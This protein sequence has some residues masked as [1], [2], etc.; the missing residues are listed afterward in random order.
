VAS[1]DVG[2]ALPRRF[3][4]RAAESLAL[5]L[6]QVDDCWHAGRLLLVTP[7]K[8]EPH[9]VPLE[10]LVFD[11]DRLFFDGVAVERERDG[12]RAYAL[13]NKPKYITSTARDPRGKSDLAP[14]LRAMPA[15]CF[16]VGRLDRETT[17]L[18]LFTND[19]ELASAVL[20]PDHETT[21]TY[22]LWLDDALADD[23]PR[24][25]RLVDGV[26]HNGEHLAAERARIVARSEYATELELTLTQ[27]KNRQ[28]R[29]MCFALDLHLVH[30]HRPRI[31]PLS[32]AHLPLG[33][34]RLLSVLEVD[35]L[36]QAVGGR[37]RVRS[38][39]VAALV[40]QAEAARSAGAP[41]ARLEQWLARES[42]ES[43]NIESD[44]DSPR[45]R[46]ND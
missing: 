17:G 21:K 19:G 29:R 24:V 41:H 35:A 15:G 1:T 2:R 7:E 40:R 13:L 31:G 6:Q 5:P 23:D 16:P 9:R 3:R 11:E 42:F 43:A 46:Q 25:G 10:T 30:L 27:G 18:L 38:R 12:T 26:T 8:Q 39:K 22:W 34:W 28:I 33:S 44:S 45:S 37:A 32:D 20:R 36:W 4:K 14:Y